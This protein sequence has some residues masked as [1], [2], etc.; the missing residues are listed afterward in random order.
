[1]IPTGEPS[2]FRPASEA[3]EIGFAA[4]IGVE[5]EE[6]SDLFYFSACSAELLAQQA[7]REGYSIPRARIVLARWDARLVE[8]AV[9]DLLGRA[10]GDSW[11]EVAEK[12]SAFMEWEFADYRE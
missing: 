1:M 9:L 12:L 11:K 5:G 7:A 4:H 2:D 3:W 6:G 10:A 8:A